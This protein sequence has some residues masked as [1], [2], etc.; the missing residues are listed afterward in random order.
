MFFSLPVENFFYTLNNSLSVGCICAFLFFCTLFY[1]INIISKSINPERCTT[2]LKFTYFCYMKQTLF[3]I[4]FFVVLI[5]FS[6]LS[7]DFGETKAR[8]LN[9]EAKK[10]RVNNPE[11]SLQV[12]RKALE[13]SDKI[14]DNELKALSNKNIG[15]AFYFMA[16]YDS[17]A[18]YLEV[19]HKIYQEINDSVGIS[20][21]ANN[22]GLVYKN[23]G[24]LDMAA[25]N[26][27]QS[28]SIDVAL[29]DTSGIPYGFSNLGQV[30]QIQG[31]YSLAIYCYERSAYYE[32]LAENPV[33]IGESYNNIAVCYTEI[34][35]YQQS[36]SYQQKALNAIRDLD[37]PFLKSSI[38]N[39]MGPNYIGLHQ[40]DQA[41]KFIAM[42]VQMRENLGDNYGLANNY[43]HMSELMRE[44]GKTDSAEFF[45][46]KAM[47]LCVNSGSNRLAA[48]ILYN[49]GMVYSDK[50]QYKKSNEY[51]LNAL[52]FAELMNENP[53]LSDIYSLLSDNY[54]TLGDFKQAYD[55]QVKWSEHTVE[56]INSNENNIQKAEGEKFVPEKN[57]NKEH[58]NIYQLLYISI[59]IMV[60][61][62]ILLL[63]FNKRRPEKKN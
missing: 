48:I 3:L 20:A 35:K 18:R 33:G 53:I 45:L 61:S 44:I 37:E 38:Y 2:F 23:K 54:S 1:I 14:G 10:L 43:I 39:N 62:L 31:K 27:R 36:L 32:K 51:L 50:K 46:F 28:I 59:G 6:L 34:G 8:E 42:S 7:Q 40:F 26:F 60:A 9:A 58:E 13:I 15:V 4:V 63:F 47:D 21:T 24:D 56:R 17:A 12:A 41:R 11:M 22:L 29:R 25:S 49:Q 55:Y 52:E 19:G 30:Y 57:E 5:P 16:K